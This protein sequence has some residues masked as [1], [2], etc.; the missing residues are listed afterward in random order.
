MSAPLIRRRTWTIAVGLGMAGLIF[1]DWY[2]DRYATPTQRLERIRLDY[3][4]ELRL[5]RDIRR[6][7]LK[8]MAQGCLHLTYIYI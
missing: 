1:Y 2:K 5:L 8:E 3:E 4:I 7:F 6:E